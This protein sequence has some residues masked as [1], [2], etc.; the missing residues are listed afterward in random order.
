MSI[1][2]INQQG[3]YVQETEIKESKISLNFLSNPEKTL[4]VLGTFPFISVFSGGARALWGTCDLVSSIAKAPLCLMQDLYRTDLK[5]DFKKSTANSRNFLIGANK[6]FIGALETLPYIGNTL[7][8]EGRLV[9]LFLSDLADTEDAIS[10]HEL[11]EKVLLEENEEEL[12]RDLSKLGY[13]PFISTLSG[14]FRALIGTSYLISSIVKVPLHL[15]KELYSKKFAF[16]TSKKEAFK[17]I[18]GVT[19]IARGSLEAIPYVGNSTLMGYDL[20]FEKESAPSKDV[21][22]ML[23]VFPITSVV[24]GPA[25]AISA[26]PHL[27]S[28]CIK[29]PFALIKDLFYFEIKKPFSGTIYNTKEIGKKTFDVAHGA[30]ETIPYAGNLVS[31]CIQFYMYKK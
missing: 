13:L 25:R 14:A 28:S 24:S 30:I 12:D 11:K 7:V 22:N 4:D 21:L 27:V 17:F 29:A 31:F 15:I 6:V 18:K 23:G 8:I 10:L 1:D 9:K 16:S 3:V 2:P 20:Y 5:R 26:L 19:Y